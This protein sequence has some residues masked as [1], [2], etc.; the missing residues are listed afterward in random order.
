MAK[1][2][3]LLPDFQVVGFSELTRQGVHFLPY[4]FVFIDPSLA[5]LQAILL[6]IFFA[7][8]GWSVDSLD[9]DNRTQAP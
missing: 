3:D 5:Q 9:F 7:V 8:E 6:S 4:R 1:V 2:F